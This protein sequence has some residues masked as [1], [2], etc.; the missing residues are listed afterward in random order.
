MFSYRVRLK[1]ESTYNNKGINDFN[2]T[3][4]SHKY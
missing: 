2:E 3:D 1:D 4:E